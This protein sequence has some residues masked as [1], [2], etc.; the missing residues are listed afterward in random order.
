MLLSPPAR[1]YS[2][3]S[4]ARGRVAGGYFPREASALGTRRSEFPRNLCYQSNQDYQD[5]I[6][7]ADVISE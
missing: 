2:T 3:R 5:S 6:L 1:I 7:T 4:V